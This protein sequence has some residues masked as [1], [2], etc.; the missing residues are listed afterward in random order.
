MIRSIFEAEEHRKYNPG[1]RVYGP[2][3]PPSHCCIWMSICRHPYRISQHVSYHCSFCCLLLIIRLKKKENVNRI[4]SKST[5][6]T[7]PKLLTILFGISSINFFAL[8]TPTS[9]RCRYRWCPLGRWQI[10]I[11]ISG[12]RPSRTACIPHF[13]IPYFNNDCRH[14][15]L[16]HQQKAHST[17][18]CE[19]QIWSHS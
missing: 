18:L 6:F 13:E 10:R 4:V 2:F 16:R 9:H 17:L 11:S 15:L 5:S 19:L 1:P 14:N 8:S 3:S 7:N 12:S